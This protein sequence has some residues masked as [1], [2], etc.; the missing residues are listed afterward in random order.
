[1]IPTH[2]P[3]FWADEVASRR[4]DNLRL[5]RDVYYH[6]T[7]AARWVGGIPGWNSEQIHDWVQRTIKY[8]EDTDPNN[9]RLRM[10]WATVQEG[11]GD[12]KSTAILIAALAAASGRRA[13]LRFVDQRGEGWDHVYA[14]VDGIPMDPLLSAGKEVDYLCRYDIKIPNP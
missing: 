13:A 1:M 5:A 14:I 10:P 2:K 3:R 11:A 9:Q 8:R 7:V 4:V 6:A 12:C